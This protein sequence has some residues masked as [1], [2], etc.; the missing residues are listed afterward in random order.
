MRSFVNTN[1]KIH[2]INLYCCQTRNSFGLGL[3][4]PFYENLKILSITSDPIGN[5][6]FK[7]IIRSYLPRLQQ[8]SFDNTNLTNDCV[9][10]LRK[11]TGGELCNIK[12]INQKKFDYHLLIKTLASFKVKK[13]DWFFCVF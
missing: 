2:I 7:N 4:S 5:L 13:I 1:W 9:K 10:I 6:G 3:S 8:L 11:H 12:F